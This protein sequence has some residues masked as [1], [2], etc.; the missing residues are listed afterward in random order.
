MAACR[1]HTPPTTARLEYIICVLFRA[2][3]PL[4]E[5]HFLC[6]LHNRT[7]AFV[8]A[9]LLACVNFKTQESV[10]FF[11]HRMKCKASTCDLDHPMTPDDI[12]FS[13]QA[14]S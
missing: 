7:G 9:N 5:M 3:L 14:V 13:K 10:F 2:C 6:I 11:S 1:D 8:H 4:M 12:V